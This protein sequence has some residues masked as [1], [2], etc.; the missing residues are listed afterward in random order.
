MDLTIARVLLWQF[1]VG[2]VLAAV[3][4]GVFGKGRW[5][6]GSIGEPDLCHSKRFFGITAGGTT[7]G[8]RGSGPD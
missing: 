3:L 5:L 1:L 2:A 6:L 8:S 4:W 7:Q